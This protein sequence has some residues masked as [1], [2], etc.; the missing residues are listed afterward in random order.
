M[1]SGSHIN[2]SLIISVITTLAVLAIITSVWQ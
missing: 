2:W 1:Q